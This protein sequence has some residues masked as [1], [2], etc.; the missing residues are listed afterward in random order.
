MSN[1][2]RKR[3]VFRWEASYLSD[4]SDTWAP[5]RVPL[6]SMCAEWGRVSSVVFVG[7]FVGIFVGA[8]DD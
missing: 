6:T 3:Q 1:G 7:I 4:T 5:E 8:G 2:G